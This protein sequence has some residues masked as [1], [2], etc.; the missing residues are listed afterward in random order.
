MKKYQKRESLQEGFKEL[1]SKSNEERREMLRKKRFK[2]SQ[3]HFLLMN[4]K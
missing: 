2:T 3:S 4:E 1:K